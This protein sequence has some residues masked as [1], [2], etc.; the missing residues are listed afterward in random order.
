MA[1]S[2]LPSAAVHQ[3]GTL[4]LPLSSKDNGTI[5]L[6]VTPDLADSNESD[7]L[8]V[9]EYGEHPH[10]LDLKTL[11][12]SNQLLA[13]ALVCMRNLRED[14]ATAEYEESFNWSEIVDS[15]REIAAASHIEWKEAAFYIVV[16]RSQIPPTTAYS[17]LGVLDKPAHAEAMKSGGFLKYWFGKPDQNGRNLATCVWRNQEDARK[18]S[19]GAAHRRAAGATRYLYS[20][21]KIERLRLLITDGA[22]EWEIRQWAD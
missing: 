4:S 17:D 8:V 18:G 15:L 1:S 7:F 22:R 6:S 11:D 2:L 14:Y 9:S 19:T 3:A 5:Q 21:W 20:E 10:L 16:F 13:K 12:T